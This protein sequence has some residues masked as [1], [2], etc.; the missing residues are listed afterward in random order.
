MASWMS[1]RL[2]IGRVS[3]TESDQSWTGTTCNFYA[4]HSFEMIL[5]T[6]H[7]PRV[8]S[9]IIL[10]FFNL[11]SVCRYANSSPVCYPSPVCMSVRLFRLISRSTDFSMDWVT[12]R[13]IER[14]I[15]C[16]VGRLRLTE[17][18][19]VCVCLCLCLSLSLSLAFSLS[20]SK[21]QFENGADLVDLCSVRVS[22]PNIF[23][24]HAVNFSYFDIL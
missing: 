20:L 14:L 22:L 2:T 4:C 11:F 10:L 23:Y 24:K 9:L 1:A 12:D 5:I 16:F 6:L 8:S 3:C 19:C 18:P 21:F 13:V 7:L 17:C 15:H